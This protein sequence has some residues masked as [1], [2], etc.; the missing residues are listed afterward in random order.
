MIRNDLIIDYA[1]D[2]SLTSKV[3]GDEKGQSCIRKAQKGRSLR[4]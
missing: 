3:V 1:S 2:L 4:R